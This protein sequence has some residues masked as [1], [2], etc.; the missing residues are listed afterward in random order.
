MA[1]MSQSK[2]APNA[3]SG[4]LAATSGTV[5]RSSDRSFGLIIAIAFVVVGCW[6]LIDGEAVRVW[7]LVLGAC[8][9][10][11]AV[12]RPKSLAGL[13]RW[14]MRLGIL[15]G[16]IIGPVALAIVFYLA[17][18]PTGLIMRWFGKDTMGLRFDSSAA[19]YWVVRDP[20]ARPDES[21][22]NQF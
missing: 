9:L 19:T 22:K 14:W 15:L 4:P 21:M 5:M 20:T 11:V 10:A 6:P 16:N 7:A 1:V 2:D 18:V 17:V 3:V 13:N 8:F 12:V